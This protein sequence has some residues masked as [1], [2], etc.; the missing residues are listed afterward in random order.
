MNLTE[1]KAKATAGESC[2]IDQMER[3]LSDE[4]IKDIKGKFMS[5]VEK[6]PPP[7]R[8]DCRFNQQEGKMWAEKL[9]EHLNS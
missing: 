5:F 6:N 8:E 3:I 4:L 1:L 7:S 9:H 2:L